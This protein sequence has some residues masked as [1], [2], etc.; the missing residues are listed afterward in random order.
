M[1]RTK[2]NT[3]ANTAARYAKQRSNTALRHLSSTRIVRTAEPPKVEPIKEFE[4]EKRKLI[5]LLRDAEVQKELG[6]AARGAYN[7]AKYEYYREY[8][9]H[10][11]NRRGRV[12][13]VILTAVV[14][15]S[16]LALWREKRHGDCYDRREWKEMKREWRRKRAQET[17]AE[18]EASTVPTTTDLAVAK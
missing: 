6:S 1:L 15:F 14:V 12:W 10:W 13:G 3:I 5:E 16:L 2:T 8:P 18:L 4:S 11:R 7:N 17:L 9:H